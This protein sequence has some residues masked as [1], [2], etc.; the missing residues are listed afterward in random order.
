MSLDYKN[1]IKNALVFGVLGGFVALP[2]VS[3]A[4]TADAAG[5]TLKAVQQRGELVCGVDT[6]MPGYAFQD[7]NGNWKG[8][9]VSLCRAVAAAVLGDA[10]KVRFVGA[11]S[12]DRLTLLQSGQI[13]LLVRDTTQTFVRN[14]SMH[15]EEPAVNFYTGEMFLVNK[16]LGVQHVDQLN[17]AT[18]CLMTGTTMEHDIADYGHV[19]H[20]TINTLLFDK[21]EQAFAAMQAGRCDG[22]TDDG[23]SVA[24]ARSSMPTPSNWVIL[25]EVI[26]PEPEG[27]YVRDGDE[28]WMNIVKWTHYAMLEGEL[29]GLTQA[30]ID[31]MKTTATDPTE[32]RFLGLDGNFG[33]MLGLDKAWSYNVIKQ[34]GNY[35]ENYDK[36]FGPKGLDL[37]R[38]QNNLWINGGLQYPFPWE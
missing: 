10:H 19:H 34:V 3:M 35:G 22:Y 5:P 16:N 38:G 15:L 12:A 2:Q 37:P 18:I 9:D 4:Q 20:I 17:G 31:Q 28:N 33:A 14:N 21:P 11:T 8:L 29:L 30:N 1:L 6:G 26:T 32:R 7:A 24:A 36:Y 13:D 27:P 25:P 23:G